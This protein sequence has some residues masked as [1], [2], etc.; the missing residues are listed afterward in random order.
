M[1]PL[2]LRMQLCMGRPVICTAVPFMF[3]AD[4]S[5]GIGDGFPRSHRQLLDS[6]KT[7]IDRS[8]ND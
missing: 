7:S 6:K 8:M 4:V 1:S 2:L 5:L 3:K